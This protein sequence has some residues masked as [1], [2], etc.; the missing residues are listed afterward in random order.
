ML[1]NSKMNDLQFTLLSDGSSD[2]ALIPILTWLLQELTLNRA[3]QSEW[4]DLRR[5]PKSPRNLT[6]RILRSVELFPCDLLFVHRDAERE[7]LEL[8]VAEITKAVAR[9]EEQEGI[10][11]PVVCV[12]PV[13]M[14]EAWLLLDKLA[15]RRASGNPNGTE[16]LPLPKLNRLERIPDPKETLYQLL[17]TAS[18]LKGRRLARFQVRNY[19]PQ[20][21]AFID[22]FTPLRTLPA[23]AFLEGELRRVVAEQA[24]DA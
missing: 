6:E 4:A 11:V 23:F 18:G 3:V 15:I 13:R 19:A 9:A 10:V 12:V 22:D 14:Q 20:V 17:R 21:S 1:L 5:L 8:R 2:R 7:M 16:E 24:W